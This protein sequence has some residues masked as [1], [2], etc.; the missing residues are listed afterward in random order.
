[1]EGFVA[2]DFPA[3]PLH[4]LDRRR[5]LTGLGLATGSLAVASRLLAEG[6][7]V[8]TKETVA[9]AEKLLGLELTDAERELMVEGLGRLRDDFAKIRAVP[10]PNDVPPALRFAPLPPASPAR[11]TASAKR[12][13]TPRKVALPKVPSDLE[14]LAFAPVTVLSRLLQARKVS[15]L[16]LTEMYLGR[17][18]RFDPLLHCVVTLTEERA[19]ARARQAD[20]EIAAGQRRSPLHGVPWG[21]KDLF[22]V[23]GH[24]TTWGAEP[25]R[26]QAFDEDATVV[27]RLDNAGAVLIAKLTLGALAM[28]DVWFGGR[29]RNPWNPEDGSSGSSA[30]SSAAVAA[31]L[32][33]FALGTETRG[34]II[35]PCTRCGTTGLRPTFGRVSRHGAMALAWSMDKVGP[36]ARCAEDCALVFAAIHGPDGLDDVVEEPF[37]WDPGLDVRTLK[38]GFLKSAFEAEPEKGQEQ[39]RLADRAA[40]E[41]LHSLGVQL[42]PIELPELPVNALSFILTVEAAAAFDELTRSGK[43][44]LLARQ[45]KDAWPNLFRTARLIPAV[46]YV[47]A[48]RVRTLLQ[49]E[50]EKIVAGLDG[51]VAPSFGN[52]T[53]RLTNLTG[54]PAVVLPHGFRDNGTPMSIT[55][56]GAL[57]GEERLLALAKGYQD[58]TGF[59]LKHPPPAAPPSA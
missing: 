12:K 34:S 33:G 27:R 54:H 17:L 24:P 2:S 35:S 11:T 10:L 14:E 47:Q 40:L 51:W 53:L 23:S 31:G 4:D 6:P 3:V 21:A 15:S 13:S 9:E 19:V 29:T 59:H 20:R 39:E 26:E 18:K 43:D 8:I 57:Y 38:L 1:V 16:A 49:R 55:F 28:G 52:P 48:N 25:Y 44:D 36:I 56:T 32:V 42:V 41:A 58:A 45:D 7:P 22:A 50:T 46:E 37:A 30:G 5:F